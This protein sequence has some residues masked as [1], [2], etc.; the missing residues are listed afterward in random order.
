MALESLGD[1]KV[2]IVPYDN[3]Y[4]KAPQTMVVDTVANTWT[5]STASNPG[6]PEAYHG[7]VDNPLELWP[8]TRCWDHRTAPFCSEGSATTATG[9]DGKE[10]TVKGG[11]ALN[12]VYLNQESD[13]KGVK[14]AVTDL[15]GKPIAGATAVSPPSAVSRRHRRCWCPNRWRSR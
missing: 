1:G 13:A 6:R 12:Y 9:V 10:R 5:Y 4:P 11:S 8:V 15:A 2:G 7:G 14:I 3:N